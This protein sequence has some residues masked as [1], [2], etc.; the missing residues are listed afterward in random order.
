MCLFPNTILLINVILNRVS[1]VDNSQFAN[2]ELWES[3]QVHRRT[4]KTTYAR[5]T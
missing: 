3:S 1:F 4:K 2:L 5:K